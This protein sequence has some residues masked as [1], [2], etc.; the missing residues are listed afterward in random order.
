[1]NKIYYSL[2]SGFVALFALLLFSGCH[3]KDDQQVIIAISKGIPDNHYGAYGKWIESNG[4]DVK[5]VDL[6]TLPF[7][8]A[9]IM[10]D[11]CSGL[12]LTGGPDVYPGRYNKAYDSS[13]CGTFD[14][15]RD[16]LEFALISKALNNNIPILGICR[17]QQI[18]NVALG[19]SLIIDIPSDFVSDIKHRNKDGNA[20]FHK[21]NIFEGSRLNEI[22]GQQNG[23]VN[24][25]HHQAVDRLADAFVV[26]A[27]AEDG[28][29]EAIEWKEPIDKPF[30]LG[31]QWHPERLTKNESLSTPIVLEFIEEARK[32]NEGR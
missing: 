29:I 15:R 5:W 4:A 3:N 21:V 10:L 1:M 7:D 31:V 19:G 28:L 2:I 18:M 22:T 24:S 6:Y 25:S 8:S 20:C 26:T 14:L 32:Y 30:F 12:L 27:R 13:R 11:K 23:L 16:T 17:G 9:L